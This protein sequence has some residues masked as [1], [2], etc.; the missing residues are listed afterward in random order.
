M[1]G[2]LL[3]QISASAF[4]GIAITVAI[5]GLNRPDTMI[6]TT[7]HPT[8]ETPVDPLASELMRCQ[9]LGEAAPRDTACRATWAQSRKRFLT[10]G[11]SAAR[12]M[13]SQSEEPGSRNETI[14]TKNSD[15]PALESTAPATAP[16]GS[17]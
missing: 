15:A 12:S 7:A 17:P 4:V 16:Q 6:E 8:L 1:E 11:S 3:A 13:N 9:A 2:K 10:S 5:I 14:V